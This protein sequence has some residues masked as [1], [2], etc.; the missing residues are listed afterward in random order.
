MIYVLWDVID[1]GL[2]IYCLGP[3]A[4]HVNSFACTSLNVFWIAHGVAG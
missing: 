4:G 1:V 3:D 2:Y